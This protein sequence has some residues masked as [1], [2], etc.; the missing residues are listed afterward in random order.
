MA[1]RDSLLAA[2]RAEFA[3]H[4]YAKAGMANIARRAK[5]AVGSVYNAFPSKRE[6]F[7]E[8]Y[9]AENA[10]SKERIVAAIDWSVPRDAMLAFIEANLQALRENRILGEWAGSSVGR[11]LREATGRC[12]L[13][14]E[15]YAQQLHRWRA[16]GR[17]RPEVTDEL[18]GELFEAVSLIDRAGETSPEALRFIGQALLDRI[19]L[20]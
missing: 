1:D 8:I 20:E 6:L 17:I 5:I 10:A 12:H 18:V 11:H 14:D 4:G 3:E 7:V 13:L 9:A 2:A 19:F 16:E 15:F